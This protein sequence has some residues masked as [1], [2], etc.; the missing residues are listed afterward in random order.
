MLNK[1]TSQKA[2]ASILVEMP[3][4]KMTLTTMQTK[5]SSLPT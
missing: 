5:K 1:H 3:Q 4:I 2:F